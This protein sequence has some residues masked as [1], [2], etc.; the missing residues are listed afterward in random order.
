MEQHILQQILID[1]HCIG[2]TLVHGQLLD[3]LKNI[4][5]VFGADRFDLRS[6]HSL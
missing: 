1:D 3:E 5:D 6:I 4:L 2:F